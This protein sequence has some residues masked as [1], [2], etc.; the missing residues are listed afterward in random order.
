MLQE[1]GFFSSFGVETGSGTSPSSHPMRTRGSYLG[2]TI[3]Q[4]I[5]T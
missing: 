3:W 4:Q 5:F 1:Y 2:G